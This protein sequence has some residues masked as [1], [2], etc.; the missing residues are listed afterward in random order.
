MPNL[1][2][3]IQNIIDSYFYDDITVNKKAIKTHRNQQNENGPA[4]S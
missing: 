3:C 2:P 4:E 1:K